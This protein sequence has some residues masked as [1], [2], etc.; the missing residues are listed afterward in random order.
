MTSELEKLFEDFQNQLINEKIEH[1]KLKICKYSFEISKV[2]ILS[3]STGLS[4]LSIFAIL[5]MILIPII[6]SIKHNSNVVIRLNITK[7]KKDLLKELLNYKST[8]Y[9]ELNES[10]INHLYDKLTKKFVC[11]KYILI[12]YNEIHKLR[13]HR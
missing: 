4:F 8:T 12:I 9:K 7:L 5:S 13:R 11:N 2:V 3:I 10:E 1:R 6:D